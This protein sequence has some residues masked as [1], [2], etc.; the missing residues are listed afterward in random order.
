MN[1]AGGTVTNSLIQNISTWA[2]D[3]MRA[4]W[5]ALSAEVEPRSPTGILT[6]RVHKIN[7]QPPLQVLGELQYPSKIGAS[8]QL[9]ELPGLYLICLNFD[10]ILYFLV[11]NLFLPLI[12]YQM[13][14]SMK[15]TRPVMARGPSE[16]RN[17][18]CCA[19]CI[20]FHFVHLISLANARIAFI[21]A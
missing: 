20:T 7:W 4:S 21:Q 9:N 2:P 1:T 3:D 13:S 15:R 18:L 14:F 12:T 8:P 10:A 17:R 6:I 19:L 16:W 5:A 11:I